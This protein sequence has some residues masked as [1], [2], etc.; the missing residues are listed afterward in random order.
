MASRSC[1]T[2]IF[3]EPISDI[4]AGDWVPDTGSDLYT[5]VDDTTNVDNGW[6][7][8]NPPPDGDTTYISLPSSASTL[9]CEMKLASKGSN[10]WV[11]GLDV[12]VNVVARKIG[13]DG[14]LQ[15]HLYEGATLVKS[16]G[17]RSLLT[18]YA[19]L[20]QTLTQSEYEGISDF[21]DLRIRLE[22]HSTLN[23]DGIRVTMIGFG[24]V[25]P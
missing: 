6:A 16:S 15:F 11:L 13:T 9:T 14:S 2:N 22:G 21:T 4:S 17:F 10:T 24:E 25:C 20:V 23:S 7:A 1:C 3:R 5:Q 12:R 8:W 19:G 18:V